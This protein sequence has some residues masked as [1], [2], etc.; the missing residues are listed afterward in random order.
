MDNYE[1]ENKYIAALKLCKTDDEYRLVID[2]IY[3]DGFEDGTNE[4]DEE[5]G[6]DCNHCL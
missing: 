2:K 4:A 1:Y 5:D 3:A 6:C